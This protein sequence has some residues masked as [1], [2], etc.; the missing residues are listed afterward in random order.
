VPYQQVEHVLMRS[1][2]KFHIFR[3]TASIVWP[4]LER[5][6]LLGTYYVQAR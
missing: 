3:Q 6:C 2:N 1:N 4:F 5:G